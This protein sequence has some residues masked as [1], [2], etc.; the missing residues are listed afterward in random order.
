MRTQPHSRSVAAEE[1]R[2]DLLLIRS[3]SLAGESVKGNLV[4]E[5]GRNYDNQDGSICVSTLHILVA[6]L[7]CC[8]VAIEPTLD[9]RE[10]EKFNNAVGRRSP[11]ALEGGR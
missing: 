10:D 9:W 1:R 2:C 4:L 5:R 3:L 7:L 6:L 8:N 11:L